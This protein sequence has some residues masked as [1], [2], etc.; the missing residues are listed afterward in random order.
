M[1]LDKYPKSEHIQ[2]IVDGMSVKQ[3]LQLKKLS[4]LNRNFSFNWTEAVDKDII[5]T[6]I[7]QKPKTRSEV[8]SRITNACN[9][10]GEFILNYSFCPYCGEV[11]CIHIDVTNDYKLLKKEYDH[12]YREALEKWKREEPYKLTQKEDCFFDTCGLLIKISQKKELR[13]PIDDCFYNKYC[14]GFNTKRALASHLKCHKHK[15]GSNFRL[16]DFREEEIRQWSCN[17]VELSSDFMDYCKN[18]TIRF[19]E[20]YDR[21]NKLFNKY[22]EWRLKE[23]HLNDFIPK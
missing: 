2:K 23:P 3:I 12:L 21:L 18:L 11:L 14:F 19:S 22:R 8:R 13:C 17:D 5:L 15:D 4:Q 6:A 1:Y 10:H 20:E 9:E 16:S 7:Q